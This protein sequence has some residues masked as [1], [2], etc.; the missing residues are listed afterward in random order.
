MTSKESAHTKPSKHTT[1]EVEEF[2]D[3]VEDNIEDTAG[4]GS[5]AIMPNT[6]LDDD[7]KPVT[8]APKNP[9]T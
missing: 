9:N 4:A 6:D 2:L 3:M 7:G 5:P 8:G 1:D